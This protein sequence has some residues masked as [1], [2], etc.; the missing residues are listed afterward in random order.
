MWYENA[1]QGIRVLIW[2]SDDTRGA[3]GVRLKASSCDASWRC[4]GARSRRSMVDTISDEIVSLWVMERR[5]WFAEA[6]EA[7]LRSGT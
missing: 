4:Y 3:S 7:Q 2:V 1:P 5:A 6:L